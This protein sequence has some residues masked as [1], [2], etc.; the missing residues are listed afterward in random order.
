M[1]KLEDL[2]Y[3][4]KVEITYFLSIM[5]TDIPSVLAGVAFNLDE[6]FGSFV[7]HWLD[8]KELHFTS[9]I[10]IFIHH[11]KT[12]VEQQSDSGDDEEDE[13]GLQMKL[14]NG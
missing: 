11:L 2:F 14:D 1:C 8:N 5:F 7:V 3:K 13:D 12:I 10:E 9:S 6:G 4:C